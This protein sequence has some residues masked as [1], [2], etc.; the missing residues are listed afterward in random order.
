MRDTTTTWMQGRD[1]GTLPCVTVTL[2]A[3]LSYRMLVTCPQAGATAA[4]RIARVATLTQG[5]TATTLAA[6]MARHRAVS[7][8]RYWRRST[9]RAMVPVQRLPGIEVV[10]AKTGMAH[11]VS[12]EGLPTGRARG[13]YK[14]LCGVR[15]LAASM[16]EPARGRCSGCA[17]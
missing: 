7:D 4:L 11:Q 16:V 14:A 15:F 6:A 5:L 2:C 17:L 9:D 10:D 3:P 1:T 13:H 12:A 8:S